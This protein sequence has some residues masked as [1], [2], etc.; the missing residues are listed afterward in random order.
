M[1]PWLSN[2]HVFQWEPGGQRLPLTA[3]APHWRA[4]FQI[5]AES[6]G[7]EPP[8]DRWALLEFVRD[9]S[10]DQFRRDAATLRQLTAACRSE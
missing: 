10:L 9:D 4:F 1:L 8:P 5:L 3:G 7:T 6:P 2:L